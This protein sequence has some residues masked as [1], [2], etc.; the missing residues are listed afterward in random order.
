LG[1][2]GFSQQQ[3]F[4]Q[5]CERVECVDTDSREDAIKKVEDGEVLAAL[6]LP[7]DFLDK[8]QA[9]L[10]GA[11]VEPASVEVYVNEDDPVKARLVD[12]RISAL[13]T[14]AN[15]VL[16]DEISG[17]LLRYLDVLVAGG[18][19]SIPLLGEFDVLGLERTQASLEAVKRDLDGPQRQIVDQVI[20][21]AKLAG[22]NLSFA[23]ELLGSVSQ[24]I[25][26]DKQVVNG[27]VPPLDTFA[28]SVA[29]SI[30]LMFVTVLLV[31]GSLALERE[32]NTFARLTRGLVG[33]SELLGEKIALGTICSVV[34]ALVL[35]GVLELFVNLQWERLPLFAAAI[36]LTG[37]GFAAMGSAIGVAAREVRASALAA[38]ALTL[39]IA[40]LSLIPTGAIGEGLYDAIR[41]LTGAFPFRPGLD[42]LT[43]GLSD[44]GELGVNLAH[45]AALTVA[46]FLVARVGMRRFASAA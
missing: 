36:V 16:S 8:L 34:V 7:D 32:E 26:V 11:G 3:A 38:F 12:D 6:I 4:V 5:L 45:L 18:E 35:L 22:E 20:R 19:F 13:I 27:D 39:P 42:A 31:A 46:Y 40:F 33:R 15:L 41:I 29:I 21:F 28:V 37:A 17:Q 43:A 44:A 1:E 9:Q 14:E 25:A 24:P 23:D 10:S 2:G 30:T